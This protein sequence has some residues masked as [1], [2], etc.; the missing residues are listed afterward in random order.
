MRWL[1][2]LLSGRGRLSGQECP[3]SCHNLRA[4]EAPFGRR[5]DQSP[6]ATTFLISQTMDDSP[7][8]ISHTL[9]RTCREPEHPRTLSCPPKRGGWS[10]EQGAT[11]EP[12][13]S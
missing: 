1:R 8:G 13:D 9:D 6:A 2:L 10:T 11:L 7:V 4:V 5:E 12:C 3:N